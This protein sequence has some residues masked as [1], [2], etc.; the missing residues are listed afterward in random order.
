MR[1][2]DFFGWLLVGRR[3]G[4]VGFAPDLIRLHSGLYRSL[5]ALARSGVGGRAGGARAVR[6]DSGG[7][8]QCARGR[9]VG[10]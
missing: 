10:G 4:W 6:V 8:V 1:T 2:R 9:V 7:A 3:C 5:W